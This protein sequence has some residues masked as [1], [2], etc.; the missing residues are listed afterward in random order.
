MPSRRSVLSVCAFVAASLVSGCSMTRNES[1]PVNVL[2]QNDDTEEWRVR[3][4]VEDTTGEEVL[5]TTKTVPADTGEDLGE[6]L[7]DD[8]FRGTVGDRFA[9]RAWLE[10]EPAGTFDYEITCPEDNRFSL[11]VE[12]TPFDPDDGEPL[13][14][15][16]DRC[17]E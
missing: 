14:Y 2:L 3:V 7:V 6:A 4:V 12:H 5:R 15:V 13:D 10:D 8:A 11:L 16:A 9:V 1:K 17:G